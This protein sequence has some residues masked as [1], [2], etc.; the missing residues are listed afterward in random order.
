MRSATSRDTESQNDSLEADRVSLRKEIGN[1]RLTRGDDDDP[2]FRAG[3]IVVDKPAE[4][5]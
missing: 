5:Q 4:I 3:E 1:E 2:L